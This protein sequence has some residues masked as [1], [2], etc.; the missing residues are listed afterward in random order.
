MCDSWRPSE[1]VCDEEGILLAQE[2]Q[3]LPPGQRQVP[4]QLA[5]TSRAAVNA[6]VTFQWD[7]LSQVMKM[8]HKKIG[9]S[10]M[11]SKRF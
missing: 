2:N 5:E 11:Y 7:R 9:V 4:F 1:V 8:N 10:V 3:G 6:L